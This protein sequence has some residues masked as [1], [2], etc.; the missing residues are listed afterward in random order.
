[1]GHTSRDDE[2]PFADVAN[3]DQARDGWERYAA[4]D[5]AISPALV[6]EHVHRSWRRCESL[7]ASPHTRVAHSLGPDALVRALAREREFLAA[8]EPYLHALVRAS[9]GEHHAAMLGAMDGTVLRVLG[10]H[11][12]IEAPGFPRPGALLD[13]RT[14]GANGIGTPL[15]EG[16]YVELVGP[17]HFIAGFHPYTCQGTP[18]RAPDGR[19]AGVLAMSVRRRQ[20]AERVHEILLCAARGV[21]SELAR[22]QLELRHGSPAPVFSRR[23]RAVRAAPT[24]CRPGAGRRAAQARDAALAAGRA[25]TRDALALVNAAEELIERFRQRSALWQLLASDEVSA[26]RRVDLRARIHELAELFHTELAVRRI[27]VFIA[28]GSSVL[29]HVD[30]AEFLRQAFR[31][32]LRA[33]AARGPGETIR[34]DLEQRGGD[35][36]VTISREGAISVALTYQRAM[37]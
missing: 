18:I 12:H 30:P 21:E 34:I 31:A 6:R 37:A 11:E 32:L 27:S 13:E 10:D 35:A 17:E 15:A 8:A 7:G 1:M 33:L 28:P 22:R 3:A 36:V 26:A 19:I 2:H 16:N 5:K 29:A 9:E 25:S 20:A 4:G 24:R 14:S 23:G